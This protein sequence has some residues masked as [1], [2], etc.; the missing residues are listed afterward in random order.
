MKKIKGFDNYWITEKGEVF[1]KV[2]KG[3]LRSKA[4]KDGKG[5]S[6]YDYVELYKN[7]K[8]YKKSIHRLL[9]ETFIENPSNYEIVRHLNDDKTD[10]RLENLA[11]GNHSMNA[12]DAV[13]NK[14]LPYQKL[15][16]KDINRLVAMYKSG[17]Y[18]T[19]DLASLFGISISYCEKLIQ[20]HKTKKI[21]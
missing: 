7:N 1:S 5:R 12:R 15:W 19:N 4:I 20:K 8:P 2:G 10:N 21:E 9:A 6:G 14:K 17:K 13:N 18:K 16:E 11:W 3:D